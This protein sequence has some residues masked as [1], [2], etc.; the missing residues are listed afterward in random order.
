MNRKAIVP[1][2][3]ALATAPASA[4]EL[5]WAGEFEVGKAP[6]QI[7]FSADCRRA[8]IAAAGSA[9]LG[10]VDTAALRVLPPVAVEGV[11]LGVAPSAADRLVVS[12]F[13]GSTVSEVLLPGG[14]VVSVLDIGGAPSLL[15]ALPGG[16]WLVVSEK[17]DRATLVAADPLR[18]TARFATGRRPF[19][20]AYSAL[21]NTAYIP[22]YDDG[23]VAVIELATGRTVGRLAAG[24]RPSG[25]VVF[26]DDRRLAVAVRGENKIALFDLETR[27]AQGAIA[28]GI[29]DGPFSLV[30]THDRRWLLANNTRSHDVSVI[31][32]AALRVVRRQ[33]VCEIPIVMALEPARDRLWV[34][35]E[36][37]DDNRVQVWDV[38]DEAG[39]GDPAAPGRRRAV[40][41]IRELHR[42]FARWLRG[43]LPDDGT[44]F[45]R[46]SEVL[47]AEMTFI[48]PA[49]REIPRSE[50]IETVRLSHATAKTDPASRI[51]T[52]DETVKAL[53][54][55]L[56]LARYREHQEIAGQYRLRQSS[57]V[58]RRNDAA[59]NGVEWLH[60]H[61]T[62]IE[63][64]DERP[65]DT[66]GGGSGA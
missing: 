51:W 46:F 34:A 35:C 20:A 48:S 27:Q 37:E 39:G 32:A 50:L 59:P 12:R 58:L 5:Y 11:P 24:E 18:E 1:L 60:V 54:G 29:G 8:Y 49:G 9:R 43:E 66:A 28:E 6:H 64:E 23:T 13:D 56:Y 4:L 33:P 10:V 25:A 45:G 19:P 61:E 22:E 38:V 36:G 40:A 57:A 26:D 65:A 62:W 2:L 7:A 14:D 63:T 42:F 41:E 17:A 47:A 52:T 55:G 15:T 31:D 16:R 30:A 21:R 44:A 53:P 3:A